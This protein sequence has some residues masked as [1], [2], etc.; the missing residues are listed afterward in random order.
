MTFRKAGTAHRSVTPLAR[1]MLW[2]LFLILMAISLAGTIIFNATTVVMPK[3]FEQEIPALAA[4][5]TFEIGFAVCAVFSAAAF[6]QMYV[7]NLMDK[8]SIRE[9]LVPLDESELIAAVARLLALGCEALII[10]FLHS[11]INPAHERRAAGITRVSLK[12]RTSSC[13]RRLGRS[14][15][16]WS[17][18]CGSL[19]GLTTSRRAASRGTAG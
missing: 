6:A 9:V 17:S 14:P 7:G 2:R 19:P 11:Y 4:G 15:T 18:S 12:T 13:R 1:G 5:G 3:L 16:T 8:K 10:H